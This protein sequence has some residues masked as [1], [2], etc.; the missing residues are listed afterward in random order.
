MWHNLVNTQYFKE[1]ANDFIR[2]G[3]V[4]TKA[5][6]GSKDYFDYWKLHEDRCK[7]GYKVGDVWIP[8]RYYFY[9]NFFPMW[10]V[11][12]HIALQAFEEA[13]DKNGR[14]SK[15]TAAKLVDFPRFHEM[16]YE[17]WKFK[18]IAWYGGTFMGIKSNGGK[19]FACAKTRGAGVSYM[20]A[21]DGVY[22][23]NFID[24]SK[25][26]YF[27]ST[28][29]YL[30]VDGVLVKVQEGLDWINQHSSYWKQNRQK[31]NTLM[32][33]KASYIDVYGNEKGSLSEIVGVTVDN[34]NKAHP[35]SQTVHT[36]EGTTIW[37][38]IKVGD[39]LF[40]S[41]GKPTIVEEVHEQGIRDIYTVTFDDGRKVNCTLDHLWNIV[42]WAN[43]QSKGKITRTLTEKTVTLQN[44]ISKLNQPCNRVK[45][46]MNSSVEFQSSKVLLDP[47]TLGILLG[48]GSIKKATKYRTPLTMKYEDVDDI[49]QYIPYKI[50]KD[51]WGGDIRNTV[52]IPDGK[53]IFTTLGLMDKTSGNKFIPDSYKYNSKEVRLGV[54]NGLLDTDGSITKDYGVIEYS[55]KSKQLATDV[56]WIAHSLGFGGTIKSR[57]INGKIYYRCYI[58][59]KSKS[60]FKLK[61]KNERIALKKDNNFADNKVNYVQIKS[62]KFSHRENAKCVKVSSTDSLYQIGDFILTHNTRGK[63]GR[64]ITF[65]EGG[66]FKNLKQAMEISMGS[67][68]DGDFWVGQITVL[69]TGGES[70]ESLEGL[71][72]MFT[73]PDKWDMLAFPNIWEESGSSSEV[74]YFIP[75]FR[76]NFV[77]TDADGNIDVT[78][79]LLADNEEREKKAKSRDPKD[80]DR[81]KAEYPQ[82]PSE[83]FQRIELND[84]NVHEIDQQIKRIESS[85][86]IKA[87]LVHGNFI[88]STGDRALNGVEFIVDPKAVPVEKYPHQRGDDLTGCVTILERPFRDRTGKVPTGMYQVVFDAFYKDDAEDLTSLFDIRVFKLEN[89]YDRTYTNLPVAWFT[90]RPKLARCHETLFNLCRYYNCTAQGE[91]GGGGTSVLDY[92]R[93]KRLLHFIDFEPE[94]IHNKELASN[95]KNR[96]YLM[97]MSTDRKKMGM[98]YLAEWHMEVRGVDKDGGTIHN[99]HKIYDLGLLREMRSGGVRNADRLSSSLIAMFMLKE[100]T[101]TVIAESAS[102]SQFFNRRLFSKDSA[103]DSDGMTTLY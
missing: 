57:T 95:Q 26:Y 17:Y 61:R 56:I 31:K 5:P 53:Q 49:A 13:K 76:A 66:S 47:Y 87:L 19:H 88:S 51:T 75:S 93:A 59:S 92:A 54:L 85:T 101:A 65:E 21:A 12:D 63:R 23:Y 27:A 103:S 91:I 11:P 35:Y 67:M 14:I 44:I 94:M 68:R 58:Y 16:Q 102:R 34:P 33:Q 97:N 20:E 18:H 6:R 79:S 2:N 60:L 82:K 4:Y 46:K 37:E 99:V 32:H 86:A 73:N 25:S 70:G 69:G 71:E 8:G 22:N 30:T 89:Q 45:V 36:P 28:E 96:A 40:G 83:L 43:K 74:G 9:L 38:N 3:G 1:A 90:G 29:Q 48:D 7:F 80:L 15:K 77:Y 62:V 10:K 55:S 52:H 41:D 100:K 50:T 81:R 24:G 98:T 39:K 78:R 84:F 72:D 64:K 42:T